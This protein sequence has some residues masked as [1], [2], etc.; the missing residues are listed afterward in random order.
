MYETGAP[1]GPPPLPEEPTAAVVVDL[2]GLHV[3][4]DP[5]RPDRPELRPTAVP[6]FDAV[7]S[8]L[9][10]PPPGTTTY[11]LRGTETAQDG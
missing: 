3:R 2:P 9:P 10:G 1:P 6:Q 11:R 4:H 5:D 7:T 8:V